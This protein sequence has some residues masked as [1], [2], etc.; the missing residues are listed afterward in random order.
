MGASAKVSWLRIPRGAATVA[1][2]SV[3]PKRAPM[4]SCAPSVVT[5]KKVLAR[6]LV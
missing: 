3:S 5:S 2:W 6:E 1:S 4:S